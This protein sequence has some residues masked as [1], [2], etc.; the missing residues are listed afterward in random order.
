MLDLFKI[1]NASLRTGLLLSPQNPTEKLF[2]KPFECL[3][4]SGIKTGK[5]NSFAFFSEA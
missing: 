1:S 5:A 2:E 4:M 3:F